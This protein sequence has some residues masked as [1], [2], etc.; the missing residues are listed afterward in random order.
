MVPVLVFPGKGK[1]QSGGSNDNMVISGEETMQGVSIFSSRAPRVFFN[2]SDDSLQ[3]LLLR[4]LI[5]E[6]TNIS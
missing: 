3:M 6:Q 1:R 2:V 5:P 4:V